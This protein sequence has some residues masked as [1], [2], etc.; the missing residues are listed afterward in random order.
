MMSNKVYLT[1]EDRVV[2]YSEIPQYYFERGWTFE[3]S[4]ELG[5]RVTTPPSGR[6][7]FS[8]LGPEPEDAVKPEDA[9]G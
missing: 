6:Q 7:Q 2:D 8:A 5:M 9:D 1:N 3:W 4:R